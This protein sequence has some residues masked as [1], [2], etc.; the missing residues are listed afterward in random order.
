MANQF[1]IR[2]PTATWT[3]ENPTLL[4]N[5]LGVESALINGVETDTGQ[6]KLGDGVTLWADLPYFAPALAPTQRTITDA[7]GNITSADN[8][9]MVICDSGSGQTIT[10][11]PDLGVN[12]NCL[13]I[14][15]GA[16]QVTLDAGSGVTLNNADSFLAISAQYGAAT[17]YA[18]A[19][20]TFYLGGQLA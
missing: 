12:F 3:A 17:L 20:D 14:Q 6:A 1:I 9:G 11:D 15:I 13:V 7:T 4:E 10:V 5:Q 8:G 2:K 18:Y 19:P 16:G